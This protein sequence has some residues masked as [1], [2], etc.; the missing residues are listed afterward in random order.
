MSNDTLRSIKYSEAEGLKLD[1]LS[2]KLGRSKRQVFLQ[3]IDYFYRT[4]KDPLDINDDL[5]KT[6]LLKQHKEYIG[7]IKVQ[8]AD[9]LI[10]AKREMERMTE[11]QKKVI[12]GF[13]GLLKQNEVIPKLLNQQNQYLHQLEVQ[14]KNIVTQLHEKENLKRLFLDILESYASARDN[15]SS[16]G[17]RKEKEQLLTITRNQIKRL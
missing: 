14:Y 3:M 9:L 7:F 10:P 4:K 6:T 13:N 15:V 5:L 12:N 8:E 16:I 11:S 17:S 1:K 2:L